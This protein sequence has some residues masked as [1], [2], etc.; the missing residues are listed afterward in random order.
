MIKFKTTLMASVLALCAATAANAADLTVWGLQAFNKDADALMGQMAKDFGKAKGIDVQYVVVPANVLTERLASAFEG[1]AAPDAFMQLGQNSQYYAQSGLTKPVDDIL[2]SM[3][4]RDGG[5]YESMVPQAIYE[6][7]AHSVPIEIDLVPMFARKD[8]IG[9]TGLPV[10]ETWED[11]RKVSQAIIKKNPQYVGLGIPL[12]N[13]NDAESQLRM[14]FWSFGGAMFSEDSKS[15]TW[16]SP[17]TVAA[18][19][20]IKDMYEEGTIPRNV[21]TWDD[22]GNNTAYQT[23]RAAFIMNPP[24]VYSW[25]VENDKKL[26]ENSVLIN[27]PKGPGEKGRSATLLGSFSWLVSSQTKQEALAKEWI[28]YFF[29]SENYEK[30]IQTT[31]GR[32][33]PIF[34]ALAKSM[35]LF[36]DNPSFANFDK[37]A[38]DGLTIGFKG[39]PTPLASQVY[40]AKILSSSVQQMI[41]DGKSPQDAAAWAQAEVEKLASAKK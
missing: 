23:G 20:F 41:V 28:Q 17:E 14:L 4:A 16:N 36:K 18:Y 40:T 33:Y 19:Q 1:K 11:L 6:G 29:Q 27:I 35:P 22:G 31:G 37:L 39:A 21:V 5:V 8:L 13:A 32:W 10:P 24:S 15:V 38:T 2:A 34:P 25:M 26:L 9:E 3:R 12:S 30:L 7:H